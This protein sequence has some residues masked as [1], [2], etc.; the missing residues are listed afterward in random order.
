M[1]SGNAQ[2]K[3]KHQNQ[4]GVDFP[5]RLNR[6][7]ALKGLA[8]RRGADEL[9][10]RGLVR[11]DGQVA[12]VGERVMHPETEVTLGKEVGNFQKEYQ[13]F[14]YY[15]SRGV[16]THSPQRRERS[17]QDVSGM[18]GVFPIGRL[19]K[20]SEGLIILTNDGRVTE[21]LLSPRFAHEK[22]YLVS[23]RGVWP[24]GIK[25]KLEQGIEDSGDNLRAKKFTQLGKQQASIVL[26]EGKKH[27]IRRMLASSGLVIT[28]LKRIRI[29]NV[30]LGSL[31]VGEGR[32][33]TGRARSGFLHD[34][35]LS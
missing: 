8:T 29:M 35:G 3:S 27:Q 22:E 6:F 31:A 1:T 20:D 19:D 34:L 33:L 9:I 16:I 23:I 30:H 25:Q 12:K 7:M 15:K 13:Y 28:E 17:I 21:R 26:T 5:M 32:E 18:K 14:A 2:K 4:E 24:Q 11:I 10:A